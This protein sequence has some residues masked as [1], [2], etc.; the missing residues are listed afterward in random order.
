MF[1]SHMEGS[2]VDGEWELSSAVIEE[3][4]KKMGK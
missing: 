1:F 2:L 3:L 4:S